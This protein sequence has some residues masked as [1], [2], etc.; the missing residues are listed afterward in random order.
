MLDTLSAVIFDL[1]GTLIDSKDVMRS[2]YF[3]AY[4]EVVGDGAPPP[5]SEYCR[6]LGQS[7]P[8]IMRQMGLPL[9]MHAAFK[10]ESIRNMHRVR[11]FDGIVAMLEALSLRRVPMAIATGKDHARAVALLEHLRIDCHFAMVL[12]SDDVPNQK[13]APDMALRIADALAL[14]PADTLFVGDAAADLECGA[15]A[16]MKTALALWDHP[17]AHVLA[18]PVDVRFA[19]PADLLSLLRMPLSCV[20]S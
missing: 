5:F 3:A 14:T 11:V 8:N 10:R 17:P 2:A 15:R 9:E 12:G 18:M 1:D 16:G 20:P 13:P 6:Y 19:A 4:D 7:F